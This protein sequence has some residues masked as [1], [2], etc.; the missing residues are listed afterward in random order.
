MEIH[1]RADESVID[2]AINLSVQSQSKRLNEEEEKENKVSSPIRRSCSITSLVSISSI[3]TTPNDEKN[4]LVDIGNG[5]YTD[6]RIQVS[7]QF[8][9]NFSFSNV[10]ED[11]HYEQKIIYLSFPVMFSLWRGNRLSSL[12]LDRVN[13]IMVSPCYWLVF[14]YS[15]FCPVCLPRCRDSARNGG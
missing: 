7:C 1:H 3:R 10:S 15:S 6:E 8:D 4:S 9:L 13:I 11:K 5:N 2:G 14:V 12:V